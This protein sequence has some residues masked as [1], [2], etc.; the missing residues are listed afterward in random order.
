[1][2]IQRQ[3]K[4][5][6]RKIRLLMAGSDLNTVKGGMVSVSRNYLRTKHWKRTEVFYVATHRESSGP[7]KLG[8]FAAAYIRI[9]ICLLRKRADIALLNVSERGSVYRKALLMKLCH[10]F[11]VPV[12]FHHHG[13]EFNDFYGTL[14]EKKKKYIQ[15]V[16]TEADLNIVLSRSQ[17]KD[18]LEKA[19][20]AR[21]QF[22]YNSIETEE[23]NPYSG[24]TCY[25][26]TMGRLGERAEL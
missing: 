17:E 4:K 2:I 22:L 18:I 26:L 9:L 8:I 10:F 16:L 11:G 21:V 6:R 24:D 14:S 13:A 12:I 23:E 20:K 5:K 3:R 25:I 7:V 15:K 19:P 1:M